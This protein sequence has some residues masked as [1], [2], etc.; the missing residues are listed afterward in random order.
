VLLEK[1]GELGCVVF[2]RELGGEEDL[3]KALDEALD[4]ALGK[5]VRT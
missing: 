3:D 4:E 1:V 5:E 2:G